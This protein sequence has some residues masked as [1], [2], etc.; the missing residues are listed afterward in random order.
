VVL[1]VLDLGAWK[2]VSR[3]F[4]RERLLTRFGGS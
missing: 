3:L 2:V 1:A 4:D